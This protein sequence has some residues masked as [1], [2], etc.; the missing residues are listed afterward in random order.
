MGKIKERHL[1]IMVYSKNKLHSIP[2]FSFRP[3][4]VG[5]L[6]LGLQTCI[7]CRLVCVCAYSEVCVQ[8]R[9][10]SFFSDFN[11]R[12]ISPSET[13]GHILLAPLKSAQQLKK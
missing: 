1:N 4:M 5:V 12:D 8:G 11:D 9:N 7:L 3:S 10:G 13:V 2:G 6:W